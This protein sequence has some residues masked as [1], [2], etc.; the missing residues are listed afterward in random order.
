MRSKMLPQLA[1]LSTMAQAGMSANV[2]VPCTVPNGAYK[3][4]SSFP[5]IAVEFATLVNTAQSEFA[6][7]LEGLNW[8]IRMKQ[9]QMT[10][11]RTS[12]RST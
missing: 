3:I 9:A 6:K 1:L 8:L 10:H 2:D 5:N 7:S 11:L 4:D 12:T